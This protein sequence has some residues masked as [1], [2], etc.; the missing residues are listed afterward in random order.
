MNENPARIWPAV[1]IS[2][3]GGLVL[4]L[5][6]LPDPLQPWRPSWIALIVI[7]WLIY[8]PRRIGLLMAWVSGLMLD[9]LRGVLLGQHALAL[10]IMGFFAL[11]F[12]LRVRV[13]PIGQQ[14]ATAFMLI[15]VYEF[16]L[17][18]VDGISGAP[19]SDWRR[20]LS[21]LSSAMVWPIV[22]SLLNHLRRMNRSTRSVR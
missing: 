19:G 13:F 14:T 7:Y 22:A 10:V 1:L 3:L 20:W 5:L 9:T 6:P 16:L 11:Q 17:Y 8:E 15:A 18:W 21:V 2:L 12:H 4:T